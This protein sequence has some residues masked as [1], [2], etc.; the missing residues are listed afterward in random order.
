MIDA[1]K[2]CELLTEND[3]TITSDC[4]PQPCFLAKIIFILGLI[5]RIKFVK[6]TIGQLSRVWWH[7][8]ARYNFHSIDTCSILKQRAIRLVRGNFQAIKCFAKHITDSS[9]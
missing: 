5:L 4:S 3:C 9:A 7:V 6:N 8:H 2:V 1:N